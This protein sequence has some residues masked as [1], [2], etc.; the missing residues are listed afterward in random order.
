M[1]WSAD[2]VGL[3]YL[4]RG[5]SWDGADCWGL[6]R[7]VYS[8]QLGIL[9][10]SYAGDYASAEE[11]GEVAAAVSRAFAPSPSWEAVTDAG[12]AFDVLVFRAGRQG[13]HVGVRVDR[14]RMLH[15][16]EG[17]CAKVELLGHPRWSRRLQTS[18]RLVGTGGGACA[19][20]A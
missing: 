16:A 15:M 6:V 8:D 2:Y 5:R 12:L 18:W 7:I 20:V 10:P 4:D 13:L 3:P 17:D 1:S 14:S 19:Q 11:A 9:L